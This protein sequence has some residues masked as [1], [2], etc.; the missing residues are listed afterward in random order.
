MN[1]V[2]FLSI[3]AVSVRFVDL[4]S[5]LRLPRTWL[6]Q[7]FVVFS[8]D[9]YIEMNRQYCE[10]EVI[11]SR[12]RQIPAGRLMPTLGTNNVEGRDQTKLQ[13]NGQDS[14]LPSESLTRQP[15]HKKLIWA[16]EIAVSSEFKF[17]YYTLGLK[18]FREL[19]VINS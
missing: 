7:E 15:L 14:D 12:G 13:I 16:I 8:G 3:A 10:T 6:N 17:S 9:L 1:A 19:L 4:P 5:H 2:L 18:P 11:K